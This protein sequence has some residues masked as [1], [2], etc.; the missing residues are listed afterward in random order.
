MFT[1]FHQSQSDGA[2]SGNRTRAT[3]LEGWGSTSE[4]YPPP[5]NHRLTAFLDGGGGWIRTTEAYASDLQSDPFD[6]SGTPPRRAPK[7]LISLALF[8]KR[9][10]VGELRCLCNRLAEIFCVSQP[11]FDPRSEALIW[12]LGKGKRKALK[13]QSIDLFQRHILQILETRDER[14]IPSREI[15]FEGLSH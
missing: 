6:R 9:G 1:S 11:L 10:I 15:D 12:V 5:R 8:F 13:H 7:E 3:S 4:L 2:G 14:S